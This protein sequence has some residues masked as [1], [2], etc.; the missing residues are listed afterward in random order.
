MDGVEPFVNQCQSEAVRL[1]APGGVQSDVELTL[2]A[3]V[4]IPRRLAVADGD[5]AGDVIAHTQTRAELST[6][7]GAVKAAVAG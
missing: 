5:D 1:P 2:D 6:V 4:D 7:L 3:G